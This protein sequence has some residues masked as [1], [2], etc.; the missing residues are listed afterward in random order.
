MELPGIE[1]VAFSP[2]LPSDQAL[3][4]STISSNQTDDLRVCPDVVVGDNTQDTEP[5]AARVALADAHVVLV[6]AQDCEPDWHARGGSQRWDR[7]HE[8]VYHPAWLALQAAR[9]G[10]R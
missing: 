8:T 6:E 1:P 10:V 5:E 4:A 2:D 9:A 7:W 3:C